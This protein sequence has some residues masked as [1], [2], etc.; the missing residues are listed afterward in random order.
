M[1]DIVTFGSA[2]IDV[3][4][5][6]KNI[7]TIE[8]EEFIT[9]KGL[10]L[11]LGSKID[12]D[13]VYFFPGGGGTNTAATF[14]LQGFKTAF[15]G[16]IGEDLAGK[17][18]MEDLKKYKIDNSLVCK[19]KDCLTNYSVV[20]KV[21]NADRTILVYRGASEKLG[22]NNI[23]FSKIKKARWLYLAPLSGKSAKITKYI[24]NFAKNNKIKVALNPGN[25]QLFLPKKELEGIIKK[26]DILILNQEEASILTGIDYKKEKEI[27]KKIDDICPGIAIMTKGPEGVVV[28]D[29]KHLYSA[30]GKKENIID[31]TGAGD[32]F[33]SGFV[34]G[35]I[36]KGN[37]E[38]AIKLAMA[39]SVSCLTELGAKGGLLKK[40]QNFKKIKTIKEACLGHNCKIK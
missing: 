25:S 17:Q 20:L 23:P 11:N 14:A 9:G 24:V 6:L 36:K 15:A 16:C 13:N 30:P 18:V 39:N 4:I 1:Y 8:N 33:G 5:R 31:N 21:K 27:F 29:G 2:C 35:Y 10:C 22:K 34:S 3:F 7:K 26:V 32:A 28:S 19:R 37:I 40:G 38:Y 12:V